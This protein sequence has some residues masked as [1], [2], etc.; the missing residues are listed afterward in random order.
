MFIPK[1][2]HTFEVLLFQRSSEGWELRDYFQI[3]KWAKSLCPELPD[4]LCGNRSNL[5]G[6]TGMRRTGDSPNKEISG[7]T[8][9]KAALGANQKLLV[10]M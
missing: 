9:I 1:L 5:P 4:V 3:K 7:E 6:S 8:S 10:E 2:T